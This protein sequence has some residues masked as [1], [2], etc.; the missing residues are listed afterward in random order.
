MLSVTTIMDL[1]MIQFDLKIIFLYND[2]EETIYL[3]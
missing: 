1:E 3:Q 2:L